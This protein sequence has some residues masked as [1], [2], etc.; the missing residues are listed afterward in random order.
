MVLD[1]S[2]GGGTWVDFFDDP[3]GPDA[4][5]FTE[6]ADELQREL[7]LR[8]LGDGETGPFRGPTHGPG[9]PLDEVGD[10]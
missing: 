6:A 2:L 7:S 3:D 1:S 5:R 8:G 4:R 9:G 10:G